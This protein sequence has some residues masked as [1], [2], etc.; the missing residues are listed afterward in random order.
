MLKFCSWDT[1]TH[2]HQF[3]F[4]LWVTKPY[5]SFLYHHKPHLCTLKSL[6]RK[7]KLQKL[8][9]NNITYSNLVVFLIAQKVLTLL[10]SLEVGCEA[11][12]YR[13]NFANGTCRTEY[14]KMFIVQCNPDITLYLKVGG[15]LVPSD[16]PFLFHIHHI[17]ALIMAINGSYGN[18]TFWKEKILGTR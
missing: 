8:W 13:N 7:R 3:C 12:V 9:L 16:L 1:R 14:M 11:N 4:R 5:Y 10:D 2:F 18:W 15:R 17:Y 6:F